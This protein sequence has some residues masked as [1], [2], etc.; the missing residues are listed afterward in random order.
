MVANAGYL[1]STNI[2]ELEITNVG[3]LEMVESLLEAGHTLVRILESKI[4]DEFYRNI[5]LWHYLYATITNGT[6]RK[7]GNYLRAQREELFEKIRPLLFD[8]QNKDANN[9]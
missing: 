6:L 9:M 7:G 1:T 2:A 4:Q 8:I 5:P 3:E